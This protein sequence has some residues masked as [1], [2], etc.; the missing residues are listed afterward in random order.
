MLEHPAPPAPLKLV[1]IGALVGLHGVRGAFKLRSFCDPPERIFKYS[2]V[3][4]RLQ[5]QLLPLVWR[6]RKASKEGF[7]VEIDGIDDRD[8]AVALVGAELVVDRAQLPPS[9]PGEYYWVDIEG[10][11]VIGV[12]GF[13]FGRVE[14]LFDTGANLVMTVKGERERLIPFV[15]AHV[16]DV[17]LAAREVL[18]DWGA[19]WL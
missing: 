2:A 1:V 14:K 7:I 18:V 12:D 19:D 15:A 10:L 4:M 11:R 8:Q 17:R 13:D 5:H 6:G 16:L 9:K 3:Q